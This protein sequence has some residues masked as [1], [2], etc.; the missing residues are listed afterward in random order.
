MTAQ[1]SCHVQISYRPF[2]H[3]LDE[4]RLKLPSNFNYDGKSF[5][6]WAPERFNSPLQWHHNGCDGISNH[7]PHHYLLN[8][9]FRH[10]SKKTSKLHITGQ[11]PVTVEF[12]A[13]MASNVE[14]VS[15]WWHHHAA[16]RGHGSCLTNFCLRILTEWLTLISGL[17]FCLQHSVHKCVY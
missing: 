13:Q 8:H 16:P 5:M 1:L 12:P 15:I 10:R 3:N 2:Y 7:Q 4:S 11:Q 17:E 6:K 14:N 9:L